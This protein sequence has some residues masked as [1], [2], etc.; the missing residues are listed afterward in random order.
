VSVSKPTP[1]GW[2]ALALGL[3]AAVT[4]APV[5][6]PVVLAAWAAAV[7]R[8]LLDRLGHAL[9]GRNAA[10]ALM[11]TVLV[12]VV[13]AVASLLG[14]A[15]VSGS[16]ELYALLTA[17]QGAPSALKALVSQEDAG[18]EAFKLPGTPQELLEWAQAHGGQVFQLLGGIAGAAAK[19]VIGAII[20]FL[21]TWTFLVEGPR[22]WAWAQAHAPLA[23]AQLRRLGDAFNETGRGLLIGVGLTNLSQAAV[24]TVIYL[25]LGIPRAIVLGLLTGVAAFV[26]LLGAALIWAPVAAGLFLTDH[27]VKGTVMIALG[28]GVISTMDNVLRPIFARYGKLDLPLYLLFLSVF[29]GLG[30]WGAF[31][32]ML[33]PLVVRLVIEALR[34]LKEEREP[35]GVAPPQ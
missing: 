25:S 5:V 7:A 26:P 8:P 32:A 28:L 29:G 11:I 3:I 13:V 30:A 4:L 6:V 2:V 16:S 19:G 35:P 17:S 31:G 9:K 20:F 34:L 27:P 23:P 12:L 10:A 1:A 21:G 33:G 24:A 22:A 14:V 18:A 15:V